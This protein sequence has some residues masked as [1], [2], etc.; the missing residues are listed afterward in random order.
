MISAIFQLLFM[1]IGLMVWMARLMVMLVVGAVRALSSYSN[2]STSGA[3]C[4]R[5]CSGGRTGLI[6]GCRSGLERGG[7]DVSA[8]A[9]G[10]GS[11]HLPSLTGAS[12]PEATACPAGAPNLPGLDV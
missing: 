11:V 7:V 1:V 12:P 8:G 10:K 2:L 9:R 6:D 5:R 3:D 4:Q